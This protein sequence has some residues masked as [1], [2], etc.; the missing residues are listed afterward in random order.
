MPKEQRVVSPR[1]ALCE[2][3]FAR[4]SKK[5]DLS[6]LAA[7]VL[8][9]ILVFRHY[10]DS[11]DL[12]ILRFTPQERQL[13][14][15][16]KCDP[17]VCLSHECGYVK[18]LRLDENKPYFAATLAIFDLVSAWRVD[19][20]KFKCLL[21]DLS[22]TE[23]DL[24]VSESV[25][26]NLRSLRE[27][28]GK[29]YP[30]DDFQMSL[31]DEAPKEVESF[32][33]ELDLFFGILHLVYLKKTGDYSETLV[34]DSTEFQNERFEKLVGSSEKFMGK[35][36]LL[37]KYLENQ[38]AFQDDAEV[39]LELQALR[40]VLKKAVSFFREIFIS[41]DP[42]KLYWLKFNSEWVDLNSAPKDLEAI[43]RTFV[44]ALLSLTFVDTELPKLSLNYFKSRLGIEKYKE[45]SVENGKAGVVPEVV[46]FE[47][48]FRPDSLLDKLSEK[49]RSSVVV[50]QN[51]NQLLK[52]YETL[53]ASKDLKQQ[54]VSYKFSGGL[55]V[56]KLK[57][58]ELTKSGEPFVFLL[59]TY[60]AIRF[61]R[62]FPDA[63]DLYLQKI[64]FEAP[65]T[66]HPARRIADARSDFMEN[67]LPRALHLLNILLTRFIRDRLKE[68]RQQIIFADGR[69][70]SQYDQ[71]FVNYLK[72]LSGVEVKL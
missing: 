7:K 27:E 38:I 35:L 25:Q 59:T 49:N 39:N 66:S 31:F 54:I 24:I 13:L 67:T 20:S 8:V 9:K 47:K 34:V 69:I 44:E 11:F 18:S 6:D 48:D 72:D 30:I 40:S 60:A 52:F 21:I 57:L 63:D 58:S 3:R 71:A 37:S 22:Q 43:M 46:F 56:V 42:E 45:S 17:A 12:G 64:P 55:G 1:N 32:A 4:Y 5:R 65:N 29:I 70:K 14:S 33:N 2:K 61:F 41:P 19:L 15:K 23:S 50:L 62:E 26:W 10:F 28:L 53:S 68:T 16:I 51:E 36:E